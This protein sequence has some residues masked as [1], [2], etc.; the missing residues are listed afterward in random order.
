[1]SVLLV[2]QNS[3][4]ALRI[5]HCAYAL[6]TCSIALSGASTDLVEDQRIQHLH[7]GGDI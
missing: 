2:E 1:V 3:R 7:L 6:T 5:S 4:I